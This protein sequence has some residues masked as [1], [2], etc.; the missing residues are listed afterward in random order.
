VTLAQGPA[1][2][3][4]YRYAI[5]LSGFTPGAPVGVECYDSVSPGGFYHFSLTTDTEGDA[6][7]DQ[8]CYSADGPDHWVVAGGLQSNTVEWSGSAPPTTSQ[9][10]A[11]TT[12]IPPT[13]TT[14]PA[15]V[16]CLKDGLNQGDEDALVGPVGSPVDIHFF[17][18][19]WFTFSVDMIRVNADCSETVVGESAPS[20]GQYAFPSVIGQEWLEVA[21][22]TRQST[23]KHRF[24][25]ATSCGRASPERTHTL[26]TA[27]SRLTPGRYRR[28][29]ESTPLAGP[30]VE[31]FTKTSLDG[32]SLAHEDEM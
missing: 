19:K 21:A 26:P 30:I 18:E 20:S 5:A 22:P 17:V 24:I 10:V 25:K 3:S 1:A 28:A 8:Q 11:S 23:G 13:T 14:T 31:V 27:V 16:P 29:A 12:T 32:S 7:T 15:F 9:T 4:G 2:P 6:S